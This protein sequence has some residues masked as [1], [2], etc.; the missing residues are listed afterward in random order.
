MATTAIPQTYTLPVHTCKTPHQ[1]ASVKSCCLIFTDPANFELYS[2]VFRLRCRALRWVLH[3]EAVVC[4]FALVIRTLASH[5]GDNLL[6]PLVIIRLSLL[7]ERPIERLSDIGSFRQGA[8][9][10]NYTPICT[11]EGDNMCLLDKRDCRSYGCIRRFYPDSLMETNDGRLLVRG[12]ETTRQSQAELVKEQQTGISPNHLPEAVR[13]YQSGR[14]E[15]RFVTTC[16]FPSIW[17]LEPFQTRRP[18]GLVSRWHNSFF[19]GWMNGNTYRVAQ[20]HENP[21]FLWKRRNVVMFPTAFFSKNISY[22]L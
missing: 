11:G 10:Y 19:R 7:S 12:G 2:K 8:S 3:V 22:R 20:N 18:Q 17:S 9:I 6:D 1:T 21:Q 15:N 13:H 4:M 14:Y 5:F 16:T